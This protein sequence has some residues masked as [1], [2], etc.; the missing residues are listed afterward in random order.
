MIQQFHLWACY[1]SN[2]NSGTSLVIQWLGIC[3]PTQGTWVRSLVWEDSTRWRGFPDGLVVKNLPANAGDTR[4]LGRSLGQEDPL[5]E[6]MATRSSI[7]AW[8]IPWTEE[9]GGLQSTGSQSQTRL[10]HGRATKRLHNC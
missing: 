3:L 5:E 4:D 2:H 7:L 9:P 8:R 1:Q 6:E 10:E